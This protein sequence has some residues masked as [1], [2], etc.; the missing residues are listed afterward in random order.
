MVEVEVMPSALQDITNIIGYVHTQSVQNA[1]KLYQEIKEKIASLQQFPERGSWV[2]EAKKQE[3]REIRL[4]HYRIIYRCVSDK[5]QVIT[6][7]HSARLL[8]NNPHL[9]EML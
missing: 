6:V 3:L 8:T 5:V 1:E 4:Y 9:D 7:H 2:K